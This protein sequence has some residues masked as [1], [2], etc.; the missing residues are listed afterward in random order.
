MLIVSELLLS[1]HKGLENHLAQM[2]LAKGD[3]VQGC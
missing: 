3:G 2:L 1:T